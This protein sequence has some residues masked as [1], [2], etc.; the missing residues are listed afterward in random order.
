MDEGFLVDEEKVEADECLSPPL[1]S[2]SLSSSVS[3]VTHE[4][5]AAHCLIMLSRDKRR[6]EV[7]CPTEGKEKKSKS[8]D[9]CLEK[10]MKNKARAKYYRCEICS[11]LFRSFQALG[12]HRASHNKIRVNTRDSGGDSKSTTMV[13]E[14]TIACP[15]CPRVFTSGQA[16]GGHKRT[17]FI[18]A[19]P[20]TI[21][22]T[23]SIP[24]NGECFDID[25]NL[26]PSFDQR[27]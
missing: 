18:A 14:R 11:K 21:A 4:E 9:S 15:L 22:V 1:G 8:Q 23:G 24:G 7:E 26:P 12:G 20:K 5:D 27:F 17:H 16:F 13:L 10:V 6:D 19:T 2:E 3:D 25:L